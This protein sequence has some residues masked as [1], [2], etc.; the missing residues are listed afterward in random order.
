MQDRH[1]HLQVF[2]VLGASYVPEDYGDSD[3]RQEAAKR[4]FAFERDSSGWAPDA[5]HDGRR[6]FPGNGCDQ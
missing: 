4:R 3:L 2:T 6:T 5:G 1:Y